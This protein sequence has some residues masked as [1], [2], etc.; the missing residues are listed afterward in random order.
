[1]KLQVKIEEELGEVITTDTRVPQGDCMSALLFILYL[2][3]AL[4]PEQ[5][6]EDKGT[7]MNIITEPHPSSGRKESITLEGQYADHMFTI[8]TH[9]EEKERLN[10]ELPPQLKKFNLGVNESKTEDY[11]IS[12]KSSEEWKKCKLL[13]SL[14]DTEHDIRHQKKKGTSN[15]R[16]QKERENPE[17]KSNKS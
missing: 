5:S 9:I 15:E 14:L 10:R 17:I 13:G 16:L 4:K 8:T 3:H 7:R 6:A 11:K 12:S 2:A 1:M